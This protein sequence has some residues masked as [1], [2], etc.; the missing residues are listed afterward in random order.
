M[1]VE[2]REQVFVSSTFKDL[3]EERTA[4][5]QTLLQADCIPSGME[6]FPASNDEKFNLIKRVID[7]CDYYVVIIG[8]RY[9][10][11][12]VDKQL[13]YTELEYDYAVE[14]KKPVMAFLHGDPGK[15]SAEKYELDGD[16]RPK[17]DEF[18]QKAEQ[19]MVRYW[20]DANDLAGQVALALIQ[21]RKTHPAE[22]WIRAGE[23]MTPDMEAELVELRA[24]VRELTADL[25]DEQRQHTGFDYAE[26]VQGDDATTLECVLD[27]QWQQTIDEGKVYANNPE[28]NRWGAS[29]TWNEILKH[30][31]PDMMDEA[32]EDQLVK[33]LS[34]L[35]DTIARKYFIEDENKVEAKFSKDP[36]LI[37]RIYKTDVLVESFNDVKVQFAALDLIEN[38]AR[39][40][41]SSDTNTYWVLT[42]RGRQLLIRLRAVRKGPI[43]DTPDSE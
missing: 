15:L 26:L 35:C 43:A 37:G 21:T 3:V 11:M 23:A 42:E 30:L 22:G 5:I 36:Q 29:V 41:P 13:S 39:R 12:D 2:K 27:Y 1:A 24:K 4:V 19:K 8:G 31:G 9:G 34:D 10:S 25:K 40:R 32:S 17:L 20:Q 33:R 14:Q 18:R 16:L 7:L 6:M 38:G 28:R